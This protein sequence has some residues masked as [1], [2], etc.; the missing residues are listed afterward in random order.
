MVL[1]IMNALS[2][3]VVRE[4][5]MSGDSVFQKRM[6]EYLETAHQGEFCEDNHIGVRDR[7]AEAS[8][9]PDYADPTHTMPE[10]APPPCKVE[11]CQDCECCDGLRGW[12][13][14]LKDV[15]NDLL[16]KSNMHTC[17]NAKCRPKGQIDCKSRFPRDTFAQT[18]LDT[19]T[20]A[21]TMKKGDPDMN[22]FNYIMT[23]LLRCNSDVT[24]LLSGTAMKAVVAYVTEYITKT[25]L[26]TYHVF[27]IIRSVF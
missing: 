1:W 16:L 18:L 12:W 14:R 2:P 8:S 24:S 9:L 26:K 7:V 6:V 21:L 11:N 13:V 15:V 3:Q 4:R 22:T 20:G 17:I 27:D 10:S 23:Y 25:G 5:L 19:G